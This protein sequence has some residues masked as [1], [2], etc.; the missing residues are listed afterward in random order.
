MIPAETISALFGWCVCVYLNTFTLSTNSCCTRC[1]CCSAALRSSL[2]PPPGA[3]T[4]ETSLW[5]V[6]TI[7]SLSSCPSRLP[8]PHA[9]RL[10]FCVLLRFF[11]FLNLRKKKKKGLS[12]QGFAEAPNSPAHFPTSIFNVGTGC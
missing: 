12:F 8:R 1:I 6:L 2:L 9:Q 3:L 7:L 10:V 4:S 5:L 11:L